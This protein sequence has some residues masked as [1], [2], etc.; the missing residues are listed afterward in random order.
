MT[1]PSRFAGATCEELWSRGQLLERRLSCG[2]AVDDSEGIIATDVAEPS[3][4]AAATA[5]IEAMR[6]LLEPDLRMRLVADARPDETSETIV[7]TLAP[8][9]I[10]TTPADIGSQLQL[11]RQIASETPVLRQHA[12]GLPLL[13]KNGSAAVL[14]HE[15]FGHPLEHGHE[16]LPFPSWLSVDIALELRRA[17]FRDVPLLRM[18]H[19]RL[20][21]EAAPF[22]LP[23]RRLEIL[24]VDGGA[25]EPLTETVTVHVSAADL[26]DGD[27]VLRI[28]GFD[29]VESRAGI[30]RSITGAS[31]DPERYPGVI[32][33][34][35]GQELH[36]ESSAPLVLTEF[37]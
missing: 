3:L 31:G 15:A 13:W 26:V 29:I 37:A 27:E 23:P 21:Q 10:V 17:S 1:A 14:A 2:Q 18:R 35:E 30:V 24:L 36:V 8:Y 9:S 22:V 11:L 4:V 16:P 20:S 5:S 33:S 7:A 34:R 12:S 28:G 19:V 6:K 25:Y 32:C